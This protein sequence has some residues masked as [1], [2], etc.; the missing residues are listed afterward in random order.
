MEVIGV[1]K[2]G[3]KRKILRLFDS[4]DDFII[5]LPETRRKEFINYLPKMILFFYVISFSFYLI[6][7]FAFIVKKLGLK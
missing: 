7:G 4:D 5:E 6:V 1:E 3:W 2:I